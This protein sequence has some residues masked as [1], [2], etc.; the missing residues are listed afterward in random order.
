MPLRDDILVPIESSQDL[1]YAPVFDR[2]KE[3]RRE[4][5]D[6]NQ[7]AWT[8]ER[9]VA[10]HTMVIR[11]AQE[12]IATQSKDLQLAA[13]L[14]E[15]LLRKE[16]YA[17]LAEGLHCCHGL[18]AQCWD[19]LYPPAEDGDLELRAAP[20][21]WLGSRLDL[22]ARQVPLTNAGHTF[23]GYKESRQ[24][25]YEDQSKDAAQKKAR[26][27]LLKE[28]K[29]TPEEFDKS[30]AESPKSFYAASERSLD[31]S[32]ETLAALQV[33]CADRFGEFAPGFG[34][35][36]G[37]LEEVR[38]LVH[39]LLERK[40]ELEPDPVVELPPSVVAALPEDE[41]AS[42]P[43]P[44]DSFSLDLGSSTE[45]ADRR[46]A[47]ESIAAA[48]ALLR[49]R[50]PRSPAPYL[51]L[52]GLRWGELRAAAERGQ[53]DALE[54]PPSDARRQIKRL[55]MAKR[56]RE[57]LEAAETMFAYPYS[58]AWLDLQ[59]L[60]V[61]ACT[62]L[63]PDYA[64][65]ARA[66]RS[67]LR[68]LLMDVPDLLSATLMD[69][70]PVANADTQKWLATVMAGETVAASGFDVTPADGFARATS[71]LKAGEHQKAFS[72]MNEE[73]NRQASGRGRFLRQLNLVELCVAAGKDAIAQ[74]I[75]EDL[76]AQ[77]DNHKI[78]AWEDRETVAGA[79]TLM[80]S[81]SKRIQGDAKE[82][83]KYFE[84]ICRLDPGRALAN[85]A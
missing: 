63:G 69:D 85:G 10:D 49:R 65:I 79:L 28:G 44:A 68:A 60:V 34:K 20:L 37:A 47:I 82:K 74:P 22:P 31:A 77:A 62:A 8:H 83:Q 61:E 72:I 12:A 70:T 58:R 64:L 33:L 53:T 71:A 9:K 15:A 23:L 29:L 5:D 76:I 48:A 51:M 18:L 1:R 66:I 52:R 27:K 54:A 55:A 6:L 30:F 81:A 46:E 16:G 84:R 57:L 32:L 75:L 14:T 67:E 73:I 7:G 24:V 36:R 42:A 80:M 17:G 45:P 25:G 2:I 4:E 19:Q 35:L 50:E 43:A 38:H 3:A 11:L 40:R 39:Q 26:E 21:D 13:W 56:W 78:E 41:S 59:R